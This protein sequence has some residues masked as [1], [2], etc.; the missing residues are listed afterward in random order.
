[1]TD[2]HIAEQAATESDSR[3]ASV[4]SQTTAAAVQADAEAANQGVLA[5]LAFAT[6]DEQRTAR[7]WRNGLR[8]SWLIFLV[9]LVWAVMYRGAPSG[10]KRTVHTAVVEIKGEIASDADASADNVNASLRAAFE[11][12]GTLAVVVLINS[13]GGSPV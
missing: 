8:V 5:R 4:P 12:A 2:P 7:R 11:D 10:D 3:T 1:M 9:F 13:P 6:L